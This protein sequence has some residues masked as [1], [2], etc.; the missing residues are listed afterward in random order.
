MISRRFT[1][2]LL[3]AALVAAAAAF[4]PSTARALDREDVLRAAMVINFARYAEWTHGSS[5]PLIFCV[6]SGADLEEALHSYDGRELDGRTIEVR[7]LV[8]SRAG[9]C[10]IAYLSDDDARSDIALRGGQAGVMTVAR[11]DGFSQR[12]VVGLIRVGGQTRFE[13]NN[14]AASAAGIRLSSRFLRLATAVR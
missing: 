10:H 1:G 11:I 13:I 8:P 2:S 4:A 3:L 5:G 9:M 7:V 12:G 6:S 14:G